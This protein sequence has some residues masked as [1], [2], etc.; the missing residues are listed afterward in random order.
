M[1]STRT[2]S[3]PDPAATASSARA[4]GGLLRPGDVIGL[5]GDLGTGKTAF[6]RALIQGLVGSDMPVPSPTFTLVQ[7]YDTPVGP[8]WHCDLYRIEDPEEC[9]ELGLSEAFESAVTLIEWPERMARFLPAKALAITF[10]Y[11]GEGRSMTRSGGPSH[12]L[13]WP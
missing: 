1:N 11:E 5:S 8:L 2:L 12:L 3:L 4:L 10:S 9:W 13:G 6:A 7:T